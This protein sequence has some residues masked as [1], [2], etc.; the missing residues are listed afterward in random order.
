MLQSADR[1]ASMQRP[2]STQSGPHCA[3]CR[4]TPLPVIGDVSVHELQSLGRDLQSLS[5]NQTETLMS[6]LDQNGDRTKLTKFLHSFQMLSTGE[7]TNSPCCSACCLCMRFFIT[8]QVLSTGEG[9]RDLT[10][11]LCSWPTLHCVAAQHY[12]LSMGELARS[13]AAVLHGLHRARHVPART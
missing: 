6:G 8:M 2:S 9:I 13:P 11:L 1:V 4:E 12:L 5:T 7:H 10:A 3:A